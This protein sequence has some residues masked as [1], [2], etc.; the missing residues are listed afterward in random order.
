MMTLPTMSSPHTGSARNGA[1]GYSSPL[2]VAAPTV[3]ERGQ[4]RGGGYQERRSSGGVLFS[5]PSF[6]AP[7]NDRGRSLGWGETPERSAHTHT[8][9][10][11]QERCV[12][13][14]RGK[15]DAMSQALT[16]RAVDHGKTTRVLLLDAAFTA[17]DELPDSA[18]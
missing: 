4:S 5:L 16:R 9:P 7:A 6:P 1:A 10:A 12:K 8:V 11:K 3:T 18:A 2:L 15:E 14:F 13:V 17:F